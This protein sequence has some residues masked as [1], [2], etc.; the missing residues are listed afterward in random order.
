MKVLI[1]ASAL[2]LVGSCTNLR[3]TQKI[4]NLKESIVFEDPETIITS[5]PTR[6]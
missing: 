4:E 5:S 1:I 2:A 3:H 6:S